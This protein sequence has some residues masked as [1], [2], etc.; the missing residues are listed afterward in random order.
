MDFVIHNDT[1]V[2][3]DLDDTLY[4]ETDFLKSAFTEI[5]LILAE[6]IGHEIFDEMM[7][8]YTS[9]KEVFGNIIDRYQISSRS[10]QDLIA[11]YRNHKPSIKLDEHTAEKLEEL[12]EQQVAL[13][14]LTDGRSIT[15]RN[16]IESLGIEGYFQQI[17]ISEEFGYSKPDEEGFEYMEGNLPGNNYV[18]IGDNITKDF[19]APNKR[20]WETIC[21]LDDGSNVHPQN[22]LDVEDDLKKPAL[23]INSLSELQLAT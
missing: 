7:Q 17:I 8:L 5:S 9:G 3:F 23:F 6:D 16:K 14:L 1:A 15:Q 22:Y 11:M 21:L 2:I 18:Y 19:I 13:G 4:K 20:G 12:Q 10:K